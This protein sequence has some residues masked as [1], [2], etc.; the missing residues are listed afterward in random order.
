VSKELSKKP[1]LLFSTKGYK[2][3]SDER[4]GSDVLHEASSRQ[5]KVIAT[6]LLTFEN[7]VM[8]S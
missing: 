8:L 5:I 2:E 7:I 6:P 3:L 4:E 1:T